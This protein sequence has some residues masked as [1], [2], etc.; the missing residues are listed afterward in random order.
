MSYEEN[1]TPIGSPVLARYNDP[2]RSLCA[3]IAT[4]REQVQFL[5]EAIGRLVDAQAALSRRVTSVIETQPS[6]ALN[7][8]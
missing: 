2:G 5:C 7:H 1:L 3:E 6:G 4:L 8:E